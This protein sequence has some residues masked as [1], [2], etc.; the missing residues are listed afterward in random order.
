MTSLRSPV[1]AMR[2]IFARTTSRYGDVYLRALASRAN[3]SSRASVIRKGLC[4]GTR[5]FPL[6]GGAY[7]QRPASTR[8]IRHRNYEM[9]YLAF[10]RGEVAEWLKA[11][12][13]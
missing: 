9:R 3:R 1:A 5:S 10:S 11:M 6:T 13:C 12:V 7:H 8:E 4:L 2:T